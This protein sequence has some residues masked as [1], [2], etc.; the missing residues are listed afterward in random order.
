MIVP[1]D[2]PKS[3]YLRAPLLEL[4]RKLDQRDT[5]TL[6]RVF[7][8]CAAS[9]AIARDLD[10]AFFCPH[11]YATPEAQM[12][13]ATVASDVLRHGD[14]RGGHYG[15]L[16]VF[17]FF[18]DKSL[19]RNGECNGWEI[20]RNAKSIKAAASMG[21][22]WLDFMHRA[23]PDWTRASCP[24]HRLRQ[25]AC[26]ENPEPLADQTIASMT[27]VAGALSPWI[28][29]DGSARN[30]LSEVMGW[31]H[32]HLM[33]MLVAAG[34]PLAPELPS[35]PGQIIEFSGEAYYPAVAALV[36]ARTEIEDD[37][38]AD[39][40][41]TAKTLIDLAALIIRAGADPLLLDPG[42]NAINAFDAYL[43]L[44]LEIQSQSVEMDID[45]ASSPLPGAMGSLMDALVA[46][47]PSTMALQ[48]RQ[49]VLS[50][51]INDHRHEMHNLTLAPSVMG[52]WLSSVVHDDLA[53][54]V[55]VAAPST[56]AP[57]P[58][59]M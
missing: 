36:K 30:I 18:P 40:A 34:P 41:G 50:G 47:L 17:M 8:S 5:I 6:A 52:L 22:S 51:A 2:S 12:F 43:A 16:D 15:E 37:G 7:G 29:H 24:P 19:V 3:Q 44:A 49:D 59:R 10:L 38:L 55:A 45:V 26:R 14:R 56:C 4:A 27:Q 48:L 32:L 58:R 39:A 35:D 53:G 11:P 13:A 28:N 54:N 46:A 9:P 20:A 42:G 31:G 33:P 21:V 57:P 25:W 23:D 1:M